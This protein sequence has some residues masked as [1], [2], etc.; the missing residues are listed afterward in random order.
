MQEMMG[1]MGRQRQDLGKMLSKLKG[2]IPAPNA[3]P[4]PGG[5]DDEDDQGVQPESLAGQQESAGHQGDQWPVPLSPDQASQ[6]L[7]G[8]GLDG[9]RRLEMSDTQGTPSKDRKGRNW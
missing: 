6:M 2:S 5:D 4:G 8:L 7:G 1:M 9:T 3:P